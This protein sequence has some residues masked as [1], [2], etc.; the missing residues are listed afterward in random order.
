MSVNYSDA[1]GNLPWFRSGQVCY[2]A[3]A[4]FLYLDLV[5]DA[6]TYADG[7]GYSASF[8]GE[9]IADGDYELHFWF[10]D[11]DI[12]EY[13]S[14]QLVLPITLVSGGGCGETGDVNG[15]GAVNVVDVVLAV[16]Y[17]LAQSF[18][19]CADLN[20]DGALNVVDIVIL[21]N[22]ILE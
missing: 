4:C 22:I 17:I 7:V 18:D 21:V 19:G 8:A 9:D 6:H 10:A 5:P 16:N 13:P 11:H 20:G 15:D 14:P 3:G 12:E 2:P 1:D